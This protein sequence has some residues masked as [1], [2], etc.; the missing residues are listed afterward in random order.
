MKE[1]LNKYYLWLCMLMCFFIPFIPKAQA[2]TSVAMGC[3]FVIALFIFDK[4]KLKTP[5]FN[6]TLRLFA[7]FFLITVFLSIIINGI[8]NDLS[9]L[10][11]IGQTL[12]VIYIFSLSDNPKKLKK[13]F[14]AGV[15]LSASVSLI[16]IT[17]YVI[18]TGSYEFYTG[19]VVEQL[20]FTQRSYLG[21]FCVIS[22]V[23]C[24]E[25]IFKSNT[26][27]EKLLSLFVAIFMIVTIF[28]ISSRAAALLLIIVLTTITFKVLSRKFKVIGFIGIFAFVLIA[29]LAN[30]NLT[31]RIFYSADDYRQS[32]IEKIKVHEPRYLI[33]TES[34]DV[35]YKNKNKFF[36]IGFG[37]TQEKLR[38]RYKEIKIP[39]KRSWFLERDF[40]T[41]NQYIDLLLSTGILGLVFF[42]S[43]LFI[44]IFLQ[45]HS[46]YT[47]NLLAC[48][49]IFMLFENTFH[50]TFGVFIMAL[51]FYLA[52]QPS[53]TKKLN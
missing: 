26:R 7:L 4:K 16:N 22:T 28:V 34:L 29:L 24:L 52:I 19:E 49:T 6:K 36:G 17:L 37:K 5:F 21:F 53:L 50:R 11:K 51:I 14:I 27:K 20:M 18:Q 23:F 1:Q 30:K 25:R 2:F 40:N 47:L 15:F 42:V 31:Q 10:R 13:S 45:K 38:E 8:L 39:A 33:W 48:L 3:A 9:E 46:I 41:H 43:V 44:I 32:F 35:F 12:L